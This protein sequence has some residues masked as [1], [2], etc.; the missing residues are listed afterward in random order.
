M[1]ITGIECVEILEGL[2]LISNTKMSANL[3]YRISK[4]KRILVDELN[5]LQDLAKDYVDKNNQITDVEKYNEVWATVLEVDVAKISLNDITFDVEPSAL[6]MI[7]KILEE[8]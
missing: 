5:I 8:E 3:A 7:L 1:K 2:K 4:T 6:D